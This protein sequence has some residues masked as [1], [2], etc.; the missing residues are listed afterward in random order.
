VKRASDSLTALG[1][2]RTADQIRGVWA[3]RGIAVNVWV[4]TVDFPDRTEKLHVVRSDIGS[5]QLREWRR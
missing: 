5:L 3:R 2:Q 4:E 1:A